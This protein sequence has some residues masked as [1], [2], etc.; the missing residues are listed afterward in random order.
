M[1]EDNIKNLKVLAK[2]YK[3]E[4]DHSCLYE[5]EVKLIRVEEYTGEIS[6]AVLIAKS[7][8]DMC[9]GKKDYP[10]KGEVFIN[11]KEARNYFNTHTKG[12]HKNKADEFTS[13]LRT[14]GMI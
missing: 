11:I 6:Y 14:L 3:S 9:N 4:V 1:A 7:F 2:R 10:P 8:D 13:T 12:M 5:T